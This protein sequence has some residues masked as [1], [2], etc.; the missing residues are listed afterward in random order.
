M[1]KNDRDSL[2]TKIQKLAFAKTETELFLDTH[3]DCMRA[4]DYYHKL[5]D[6]LDAAREEYANMYGPITAGES[7]GDR[8]TWIEG[9]WPWQSGF[10]ENGMGGKR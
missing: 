6:E 7:M 5:V 8:W 1:N 2:M 4:L 9:T 3:P 10:P